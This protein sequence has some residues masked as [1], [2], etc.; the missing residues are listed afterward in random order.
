MAAIYDKAL[1][2]K[3][4]SGIITSQEKPQDGNAKGDVKPLSEEKQSTKGSADVGK[5]VN[6]MSG[7]ASKVLYPLLSR[8]AVNPSFVDLLLGIEPVFHIYCPSRY[9]LSLLVSLSV[10]V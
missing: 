9:A 1:K 5:I 6:M 7:D 10:Y 2:R 3:D 8:F 4:L